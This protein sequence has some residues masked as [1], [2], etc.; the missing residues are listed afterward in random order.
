[1]HLK[2]FDFP[3]FVKWGENILRSLQQMSPWFSLGK[4][5]SPLAAVETGKV[6]FEVF[7]CP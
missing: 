1:M 7:H 2:F 5:R 6:N 4:D 3:P